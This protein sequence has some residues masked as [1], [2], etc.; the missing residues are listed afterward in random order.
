MGEISQLLPGPSYCTYVVIN[1]M[2]LEVYR[3]CLPQLLVIAA[4]LIASGFMSVYHMA[5]DTIFIC[6]SKVLSD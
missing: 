5:V 3:Q 2:P 6:A 4:Y 1:I